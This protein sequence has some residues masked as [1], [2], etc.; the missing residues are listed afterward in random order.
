MHIRTMEIK[1]GVD[2]G[3][4]RITYDNR[5]KTKIIDRLVWLAIIV[6]VVDRL[7]QETHTDHTN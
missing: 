1:A 6:E 4:R 3:I 2:I 5:K 7:I